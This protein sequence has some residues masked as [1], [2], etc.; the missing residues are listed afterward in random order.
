MPTLS[1][2]EAAEVAETNTINDRLVVTALDFDGCIAPRHFS[3]PKEE[4]LDSERK[5]LAYLTQNNT[6]VILSGSNR[7]TPKLDE[8]NAGFNRAGS[9]NVF[10]WFTNEERTFDPFLLHDLWATHPDGTPF[11]PGETIENIKPLFSDEDWTQGFINY[12]RSYGSIKDKEAFSLFSTDHE[13]KIWMKDKI[14]LVYAH[15]H[16][17]ATIHPKTQITYQLIDDKTTI[18]SSLSDFYNEHPELV[19]SNL[20]IQFIRKGDVN[21]HPIKNRPSEE[22]FKSHYSHQVIR[23]SANLS[24]AER[25][26]SIIQGTGIIDYNFRE[27]VKLLSMPENNDFGDS[28]EY[29]N[30]EDAEDY[31]RFL[32]DHAWGHSIQVGKFIEA[33]DKLTNQKLTPFPKE[34]LNLTLFGF[35]RRYLKP[36]ENQPGF[37]AED[38]K[39]EE[40][41][42]P[43][44]D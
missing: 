10:P 24:E 33:R 14:N 34:A 18:L 13:D 36:L 35:N 25:D 21:I 43:S 39:S 44:L 37:E 8:N 40:R 42:T 20:Q 2:T 6:R 17:M 15:I 30:F 29:Y 22:R 11:S 3:I 7:T 4:Y 16:Y 26:Q 12:G 32:Q 41:Y 5:L 19:P 27:T 31:Q 9:F 1:S 38:I 28:A 23:K